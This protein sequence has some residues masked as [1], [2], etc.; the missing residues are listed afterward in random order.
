LDAYREVECDILLFSGLR[1][2]LG[3]NNE[4]ANLFVRQDWDQQNCITCETTFRCY[5]ASEDLT[6]TL[7]GQYVKIRNRLE[8]LIH[9]E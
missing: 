4:E 5:T 2:L 3:T 7:D 9:T 8:M 6:L 1:C